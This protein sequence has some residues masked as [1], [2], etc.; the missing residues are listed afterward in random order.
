M[1]E[2]NCPFNQE[3][4]SA[5]ATGN[6]DPDE[7]KI[8]ERHLAQCPECRREVVKFEETWW[9]L[10]TWEVK[11]ERIPLQ[12]DALYGRLLETR[13]KES[14][15]RRFWDSLSFYQTRFNL[16]PAFVFATVLA[17]IMLYP[18]FLYLF[19]NDNIS[20]PG[21]PVLVKNNY[22]EITGADLSSDPIPSGVV[23]GVSEAE[24]N[25]MFTKAVDESRNDPPA[26]EQPG[27]RVDMAHLTGMYFAPNENMPVNNILTTQELSEL[28]PFDNTIPNPGTRIRIG[29]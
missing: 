25:Y 6:V 5:F 29:Y 14:P 8:V 9:L 23:S 27:V 19:T 2:V 28:Q 10:D 17:A 12:F 22:P 15:W 1:N 21:N 18:A 3:L 4:L 20:T 24:L 16:R 11:E 26:T 7:R 13:Q